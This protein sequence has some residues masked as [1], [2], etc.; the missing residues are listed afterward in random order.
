M[1]RIR[2]L[3]A[4][5]YTGCAISQLP[6]AQS[7]APSA[8]GYA[9]LDAAYRSLQ[10]KEYDEAIR[11][12]REAL[13]A[14][15]NRPGVH[16]DLAY[17]YLKTGE[18]EAARDEFHEAMRLDPADT[19]AAMEFAFLCHETRQTAVARRLFDRIRKQGNTTAAEAFEN[20]DRPLREGID[21]WSKAVA[22][23]P[24]NFSAH[25]ELARLAEQR[26]ET[27]LA[28]VEFEAARKLR[29]DLRELLLDV[30]RTWKTLGKNDQAHAALLAA[31][32][33][34]EGIVAE[35]ARELLPA[36]YPYVYEFRAA[37]SLDPDNLELHRELAYLLLEMKQSPEAE[38]E[39][40]LLVERTPDDLL[41]IA[42]L[43]FL[44]LA[45][46]DTAGAMPLLQKVL[47]GKDEELA[48]RVRSALKLPQTLKRRGDT[49]RV[50]VS[51]EAK[52]LAEHSFQAGYLKDA[53]KY[54]EI[55]HEIDPLDFQVMLKLGWTNN[56]L[57]DDR[58]ALPWFNLAKKSPDPVVAAEAKQASKNLEGDQRVVRSTV[59]L[60]PF[61]SSRWSDAFAYGQWKT[62]LRFPKWPVKPYLSA[63]F[64]GDTRQR[65]P[66]VEAGYLSESALIAAIGLATPTYRGVTL[67]GEAGRAFSYQKDRKGGPDYR[68]GLSLGR[69]FG[70]LLGSP[71]RGA[72]FETNDDAVFLSRFDRN[73]LFYSQNRLG[74]SVRRGGVAVQ[75]HW[76]AP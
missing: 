56:M 66:G 62:E 23:S 16:K 59:W 72:V 12:F 1:R 53:K 18:T 39:F 48:D 60:F 13:A 40:A 14:G 26:D 30:G 33:S 4:V 71:K 54:L 50:K 52:V 11:L 64:V 21:R 47:E 42:Q 35:A 43:G 27:P 34:P 44:L 17:T 5:V 19:N 45:R 73:L 69:G 9:Q 24:G 38:K 32:R 61:Y 76:S 70:H 65:L 36:R 8:P 6:A 28:A 15:A 22:A 68:G 74:Y 10:K 49:P 63:R 41:S 55:A 51:T 7:P 75:A 29:P 37:L 46:K 25:L 2:L 31:S 58:Q 67:W 20:V 3:L 57:H